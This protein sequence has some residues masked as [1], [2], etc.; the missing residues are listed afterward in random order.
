MPEN[1][2]VAAQHVGDG[3]DQAQ[4]QS[5]QKHICLPSRPFDAAHG[6]WP[7]ALAQGRPERAKRV[8]SKDNEVEPRVLPVGLHFPRNS[9]N[10]LQ[11]QGS[12]KGAVPAEWKRAGHSPYRQRLRFR[13]TFTVSHRTF[14][15]PQNL[16]W[17]L[18]S[19]IQRAGMI[20]IL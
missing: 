1:S 4:P 2:Q 12:L 7:W 11:W 13:R 8:E 6:L 19:L 20:P 15:Y 10:I 3:C 5:D 16:T 17:L 9:Q 14:R 18:G